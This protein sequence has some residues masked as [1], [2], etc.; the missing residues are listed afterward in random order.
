MGPLNFEYQ[1]TPQDLTDYQYAVKNRILKRSRSTDI[2]FRVW[3]TLL[4]MA[5]IGL[6]G[7]AAVMALPALTGHRFAP[8]EMFAGFFLGLTALFAATWLNYF[9]QRRSLVKPS[10]PTYSRHHAIVDERG[11]GIS[12]DK[13][14]TSSR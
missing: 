13:I 7:I 1:L 12:T 14:E 6:G 5:M 11:L 3:G 2:W 8:E 9:Y 4:I 10:G